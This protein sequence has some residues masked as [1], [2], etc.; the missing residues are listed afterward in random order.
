MTTEENLENKTLREKNVVRKRI[1]QPNDDLSDMVMKAEITHLNQQKRYPIRYPK[2]KT[3]YSLN[4][5]PLYLLVG[6]LGIEPR[7]Y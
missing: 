7:T 5:N 3:G 4:C 1:S 2:Q 6:R